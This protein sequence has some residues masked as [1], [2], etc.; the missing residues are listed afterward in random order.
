MAIYVRPTSFSDPVRMRATIDAAFGYDQRSIWVRILKWWCDWKPR[1]IYCGTEYTFKRM[2]NEGFD[3]V[4]INEVRRMLRRVVG[5]F[6]KTNPGMAAIVRPYK[7]N[8]CGVVVEWNYVGLPDWE[9][10][11]STK[12]IYKEVT[13]NLHKRFNHSFPEPNEDWVL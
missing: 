4:E 13:A 7:R 3:P 10:K 5:G 8:F 12:S 2:M 1:H 9:S 11:S 6:C